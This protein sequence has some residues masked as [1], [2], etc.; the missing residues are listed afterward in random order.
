MVKKTNDKGERRPLSKA[1]TRKF[2]RW[3]HYGIKQCLKEKSQVFIFF[4][5]LNYLFY[6]FFIY[7]LSFIFIF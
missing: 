6:N 1:T 7:F 3:K 2:Q 4:I 5:Y